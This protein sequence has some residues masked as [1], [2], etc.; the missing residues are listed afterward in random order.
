MLTSS[1]P[2]PPFAATRAKSPKDVVVPRKKAGEPDGDDAICV[3]AALV[4]WATTASVVAS[5]ARSTRVTSVPALVDSA[6][7]FWLVTL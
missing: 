7:P 1:G 5:G 4:Y 2:K 3:Q 6:T